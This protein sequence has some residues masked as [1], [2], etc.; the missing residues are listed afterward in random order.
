MGTAGRNGTRLLSQLHASH[1]PATT[2]AT[3]GEMTSMAEDVTR[4]ARVRP[5]YL[6]EDR[7]LLDGWL[8]FHRATLMVKCDGLT[9]AQRKDRPISTSLL[10]LHGLVR[11][12]AETE[13][14]WFQR[15]LLRQP[16]LPRIW[17]DPEVE[18]SPLVPLD[19]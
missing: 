7:E 15:V 14:N 3:K 1:D 18:G 10:S 19:Q 12:L 8:D 9:D 17:Y 6:R 4:Q 2:F 5:T 16:D 13:R 11:H